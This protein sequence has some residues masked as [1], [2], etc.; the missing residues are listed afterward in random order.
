MKEMVIYI[1]QQQL[2]IDIDIILYLVCHF[3][4]LEQGPN[5]FSIHITDSPDRISTIANWPKEYC[6][7]YTKEER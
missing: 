3:L 5:T 4:H 7:R 2:S 1:Y 6:F